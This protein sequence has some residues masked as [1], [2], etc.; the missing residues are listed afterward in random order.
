[1][2]PPTYQQLAELRPADGGSAETADRLEQ[3]GGGQGYDTYEFPSEHHA[4]QAKSD[5]IKLIVIASLLM[6]LVIVVS[7]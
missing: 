5:R 2:A 6:V 1:M 7:W 3:G 4:R